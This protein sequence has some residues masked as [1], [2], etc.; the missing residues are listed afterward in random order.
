MTAEDP[1]REALKKP[2]PFRRRFRTVLL[3]LFEQGTVIVAETN[4]PE[5]WDAQNAAQTI[6]INHLHPKVIADFSRPVLPDTGDFYERFSDKYIQEVRKTETAVW[7]EFGKKF[8]KRFEDLDSD[9][10]DNLSDI[11]AAY[12]V[13]SR[14]ETAQI[15]GSEELFGF[16]ARV[17]EVYETLLKK[18]FKE[19]YSPSMFYKMLRENMSVFILKFIA[20]DSVI[21]EDT[22]LFAG[23]K[24]QADGSL[25]VSGFSLNPIVFQLGD[26][27]ELLFTKDFTNFVHQEV[28]GKGKTSDSV[29]RTEDRGCPVL[30]AKKE[31]RDGII[32][33]AIEELIAQHGDRFGKK[34]A[35]VHS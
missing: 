20:L 22:F 14:A 10:L 9:A 3:S 13:L 2:L 7:R 32:S 8:N 29:G 35:E 16:L 6:C 27:D 17:S 26:N 30:F 15:P 5:W 23:A 31:V 12:L 28:E 4:T 18:K 24:K 21:A 34:T 33:F 25:S 19:R 1:S 11:E